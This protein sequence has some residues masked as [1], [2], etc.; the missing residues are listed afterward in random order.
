MDE[1]KPRAKMNST[2]VFAAL[3][4]EVRFERVG[5]SE[6]AEERIECERGRE[7]VERE[8]KKERKRD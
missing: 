6:G 5:E 4:Q 2:K 1:S 7:W 3:Q 8:R